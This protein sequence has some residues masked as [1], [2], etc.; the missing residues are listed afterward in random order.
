MERD[1]KTTID[2]LDGR[3]ELRD[4]YLTLG[5]LSTTDSKTI[6]QDAA[7]QMG[8]PITFSPG[9]ALNRW[10]ATA[11]WDLPKMCWTRFAPQTI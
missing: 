7:G 3:K 2:V 1:Q 8:L 5:Y 6:L 4:S 9:A 11:M 10:K